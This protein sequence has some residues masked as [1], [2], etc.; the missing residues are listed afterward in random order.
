MSKEFNYFVQDVHG[1]VPNTDFVGTVL[2][3]TGNKKQFVVTGFCWLGATDEWGFRHIGPDGVEC[4]RPLSHILGPRSNGEVRYQ[5]AQT[6]LE[7]IHS[8]VGK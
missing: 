1:Y 5:V 8:M 7:T 4:C 3:H 6:V 2:V